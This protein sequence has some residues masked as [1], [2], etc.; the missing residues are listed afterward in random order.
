VALDEIGRDFHWRK[1]LAN[2]TV[3]NARHYDVTTT[4][5]QLHEL[6]LRVV[7]WLKN[8]RIRDTQVELRAM[9]NFVAA[10]HS[11]LVRIVK[12]KHK[13]NQYRPELSDGCLPGAR[14]TIDPGLIAQPAPTSST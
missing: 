12:R 8:W 9:V 5:R 10:D 11:G 2:A 7:C 3:D 4:G 1:T 14:L 6:T 13:K